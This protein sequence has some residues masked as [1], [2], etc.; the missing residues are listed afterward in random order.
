MREK[1]GEITADPNR[2]S[3]VLDNLLSNSIRFVESGK[4]KIILDARVTSTELH[5]FISDNGPGFEKG[6]EHEVFQ[7][8]YQGRS[9]GRKS[10]HA[11]LGLYIAKSIVVKHGGEIYASQGDE[12]GAIV[13]LSIPIA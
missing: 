13:T 11:G 1:K 9:G 3:Q 12:G 10:G 5:L 4:G 7:L 2:L 6:T 8:F